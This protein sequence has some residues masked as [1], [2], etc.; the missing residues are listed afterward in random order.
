M[1][2]EGCPKMKQ[3]TILIV[4]DEENILNSLGRL[5]DDLGCTVFFAYDGKKGLEII[6]DKDIHM[7]I[8]DYRMPGMDGIKFLDEVKKISPGTI[9]LMLTGYADID[10]AIKA[11]N[12]GEVYRFITKP[13]NNIELL[14]TV[15]QGL[16]YFNMQRELCRLNKLIQSQNEALKEWNSKLEQKVSEQTKYIQDFFLESIKSLVVA[17]E[18]K[19]KYTEGHSRRVS[20]YATYIC[21]KMSLPEAFIEDVKLG[22]LLH[23]I[24]KIG[25]KESILG[26]NT[27]L[28]KE[29]YEHI[30][31]HPSIGERILTPIIKNS[32]VINI[33]RYHHEHLDG[34]G[35]PDGLKGAVIPLE[36][37]IVAVADAH[38]ALL[39]ERPYRKAR[40]P[41]SAKKELVKCAD[42]QFDSKVVE[43]L[44]S[45]EHNVTDSPFR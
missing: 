16:E 7:V 24:G 12:E 32:T 14:V 9:R 18:V 25:I 5:L 40:D 8:S 45:N 42:I 13:W 21:R 39:S 22:S 41:L 44:T 29:E 26:K 23:D 34:N 38:D 33:I 17:L 15:N 35:Y 30:K 27:G 36:A 2:N 28:T 3:N 11:I 43:I 1:A 19:D 10:L 31:T 4:D 6:K 20:E 37:R